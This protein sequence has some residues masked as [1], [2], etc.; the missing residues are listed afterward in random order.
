MGKKLGGHKTPSHFPISV[1]DTL[2][3]KQCRFTPTSNR[4]YTVRGK[5]SMYSGDLT[6]G[7][8]VNTEEYTL[9]TQ[10]DVSQMVSYLI[11]CRQNK[12]NGKLEK[13]ATFTSKIAG[14]HGFNLESVKLC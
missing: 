6:S 13:V 14:G 11:V 4:Q 3:M 9:V 5:N 1:N 7:A 8:V 12:G 2:V 10:L